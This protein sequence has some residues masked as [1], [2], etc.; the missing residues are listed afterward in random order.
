MSRR[1]FYR[2]LGRTLTFVVLAHS[3]DISLQA[4]L[5]LMGINT[6]GEHNGSE[7]DALSYAIAMEEISRGCASVGVIMSAHNSLYLYPIQAFGSQQLQ[8]EFVAP[9]AACVDGGDKLKVGCFGLSEPGNGSDAGA[10]STTAV[11]D[12]DEWVINGTKAWITNAHEAGAA[13]VFATTDKSLKY[14]TGLYCCCRV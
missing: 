5:G 13:V 1:V 12:G 10:A 2:Q 8:E 6:S 14:V 9:Y 11:L 4:E 3:L 7:L